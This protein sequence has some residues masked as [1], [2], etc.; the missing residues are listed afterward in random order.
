MCVKLIFSEKDMSLL[1]YCSSQFS[2]IFILPFL[3]IFP[4]QVKAYDSDAHA[5][6][7]ISILGACTF[8]QMGV[9]P[10]SKIMDTAKVTYKKQHGNPNKID[11]NKAI[12][13]AEKLDK[14]TNHGCFN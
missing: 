10:R 8:S 2:Y 6:A 3:I 12:S 5:N 11:W 13:I 1:K 9:I 14:K 7:A 4:S